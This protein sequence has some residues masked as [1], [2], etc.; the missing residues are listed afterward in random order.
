MSQR[1]LALAA[2]S[3]MALAACSAGGTTP[4]TG[5]STPPVS[6]SPTAQQS[7][8]QAGD[9]PV[10]ATPQTPSTVTLAFGGDVHFANQLAP[11]LDDP[12]AA[13]AELRPYLA[14]ADLAM[15]NLETAITT[16]GSE[17]PKKFR[18]RAPPAA[19]DAVAGAGVD[20]VTMANNH[21]VDYGPV[22]L[23]DTLAARAKSPVAVVGLGR[24]RADALAPAVLTARGVRV[25]FLAGTQVPDWTLA[26][27]SATAGRPGVASAADPARLAAAVRRARSQADVVVVYLHWGTDYT[28]CPNPLQRRT[29]AALAEAGADVVVGTHAHRVQ[30]AG[31]LGDTYV[32]YGLGNFVWWRRNSELDSRSGVL[33]LTLKGRRVVAE[34]WTP[35]RVSADGIPR[36]PEPAQSRRL[37]QQWLDARSCTGLA[38]QPTS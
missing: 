35:L 22:G 5:P 21:A 17:Q 29:A 26:T 20:V 30:G 19:L 16:R 7:G 4:V 6:Q 27:W 14:T 31:W 24:D 28:T 33:T 37:Q 1:F 34:R 18:F 13:L 36:E 9:Q 3:A 12:A 38:G 23:D 25:A 15:V 2:V 11:R 10:D 32:A 8:T